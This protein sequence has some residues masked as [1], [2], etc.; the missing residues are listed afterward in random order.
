MAEV[1]TQRN[2][3]IFNASKKELFTTNSGF[4]VLNRK[5]KTAWKVAQNKDEIA[6]DRIEQARVFVLAG[7]KEKF[8]S[9]EFETLKKYVETGGSLL[10]M[11]GEGGDSKYNTNMNFFLEEYGIAVNNDAVVR[12]HFYKYFHPK[13]ALIANGVLNRAISQAAGKMVGVT[14]D[15]ENNA[16]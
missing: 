4:K 3:V 14:E 8:T 13:E 6:D 2:T 9:S 15:E 7:P 5:L 11:M 1:S 10:V 12:T 16:Q